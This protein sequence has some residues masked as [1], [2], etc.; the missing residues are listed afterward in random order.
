MKTFKHHKKDI[1]EAG[2]GMECGMAIDG[3]EDLVEGDLIQAVTETQ[4]KR[5][6]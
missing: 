4:S 2:K 3:F 1:L 6:I 5:T